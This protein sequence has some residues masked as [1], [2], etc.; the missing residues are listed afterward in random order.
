MVINVDLNVG[1]KGADERQE[2]QMK[3][4]PGHTLR[5]VRNEAAVAAV[6][7]TIGKTKLTEDMTRA[8]RNA[9]KV[10]STPRSSDGAKHYA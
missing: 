5:G 6:N 7:N 1:D 9:Q 2:Q 3:H 4:V 10:T 8:M